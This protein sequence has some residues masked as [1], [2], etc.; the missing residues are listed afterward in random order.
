M[1]DRVVLVGDCSVVLLSGVE[2]HPPM[3]LLLHIQVFGTHHTWTVAIASG[4]SALYTPPHLPSVLQA[5]AQFCFRILL[6]SPISSQIIYPQGLFSN[7]I[8]LLAVS[9]C[10]KVF[11]IMFSIAIPSFYTWKILIWIYISA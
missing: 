8:G 9:N 2:K 4:G 11:P 6:K 7:H 10:E 1:D 5:E 3:S